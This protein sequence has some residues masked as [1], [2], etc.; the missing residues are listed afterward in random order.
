MNEQQQ[1]EFH[2]VDITLPWMG[3]ACNCNADSAVPQWM[4][5]PLQPTLCRRCSRHGEIPSTN[6][7]QLSGGFNK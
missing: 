2:Y 5:L 3:N 1:V 4:A 6:T 7:M